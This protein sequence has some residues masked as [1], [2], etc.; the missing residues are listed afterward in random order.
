MKNTCAYDFDGRVAFITGGSTGIGQATARLFAKSNAK[1]MI[2]DI[3]ADGGIHLAREIHKSGGIA[4]FVKCDVSQESQVRDAIS[5]TLSKF[6]RL[7][8]AFN[9]SGI[10]GEAAITD[11]S[12]TDN[13]DRT[14]AVNLKG[15]YL[16]MKY[17][18]AQMLKQGS[19]S[20]VNCSSI[21]G[22][23]GFAGIPAYVASK[24][25]VLGLTKTAALEYAKQNIRINAV[26]PGVIQ[27]PMIAR[28]T[29]GEAQAQQ[30]LVN[31]EPIGRIGKPEEIAETVLWLSSD[32]SSFVTGLPLVADGGWV[33]Q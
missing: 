32:A 24:H 21:A 7:D 30:Q 9:N 18:I 27:T 23:V 10:E 1:V 17:Q 33:A 16:C 15:V 20:I 4:E 25:G 8:F 19:G 29:H 28:F 26:C 14:L 12:S 3:N 22:L 11:Q 2:A 5:Q 31:G 6:G 13:W